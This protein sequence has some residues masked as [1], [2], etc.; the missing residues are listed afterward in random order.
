MLSQS[1][2]CPSRIPRAE[3]ALSASGVHTFT[4]RVLPESN[5]LN[6]VQRKREMLAQGRE[7]K[8]CARG[9]GANNG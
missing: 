9:C 6:G 1:V 2:V 8:R 4:Q 5:T 3:R 7:R